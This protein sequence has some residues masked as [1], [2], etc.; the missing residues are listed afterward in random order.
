MGGIPYLSC[1]SDEGNKISIVM[2]HGAAFKKEDWKR[3]DILQTLCNNDYNVMALDLPVRAGRKELKDALKAIVEDN[4][5]NINQLPITALVT[6]SASGF[7]IVDW[8]QNADKSLSQYIEKW[9]PVAPGSVQQATTEELNLLSGI[10][11][12]AIYGSKD[13]MGKKVSTRL[14]S[15]LSEETKVVEIPNATHPCYLDDPQRFIKEVV[16]FV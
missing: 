5:N 4:N 7:T 15:N 11:I 2:L 8:I 6:P 3:G 1:S 16:Q 14:G 10:P 12:L 9:I 13:S